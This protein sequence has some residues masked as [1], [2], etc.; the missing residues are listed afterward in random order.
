MPEHRAP[1]FAATL[2][3]LLMLVVLTLGDPALSPAVVSAALIGTAVLL[4]TLTLPLRLFGAAQRRHATE[5]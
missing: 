4:M 1:Y 2:C 5:E 3:L